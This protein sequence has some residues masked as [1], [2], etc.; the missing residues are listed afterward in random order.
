MAT[1]EEIGMGKR[2]VRVLLTMRYN[3]R[4]NAAT[5][6]DD[7]DSGRLTPTQIVDIANRDITNYRKVIGHVTTAIADPA[8][9]AKIKSGIE[10]YGVTDVSL[11]SDNYNELLAVIDALDPIT[12]ANLLNKSNLLLANLTAYDGIWD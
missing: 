5:Y 1:I 6:I 7:L 10:A 2:V 4:R 9:R 12:E 3:M 11:V 8:R